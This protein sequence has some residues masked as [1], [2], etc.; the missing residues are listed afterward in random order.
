MSF[1]Q[2]LPSGRSGRSGPSGGPSQYERD[3]EMRALATRY[4]ALEDIARAKQQAKEYGED[5]ISP[6]TK[7]YCAQHPEI[8]FCQGKN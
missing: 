8:P 2:P 1:F 4:A 5:R 3:A 7:A 6:Q